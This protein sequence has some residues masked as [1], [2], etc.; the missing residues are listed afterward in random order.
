MHQ[1]SALYS[2]HYLLIKLLSIFLFAH[3]HPT[4]WTAQGLM[5]C[6]GDKISQRYRRGMYTGNDK[7]SNMSNISHQISTYL[8]SYLAKLDKIQY[9][10]ICSCPGYDH[11]RLAIF[12][13]LQDFIIIQYLSIFSHPVKI[14]LKE[15]T[16]E[17]DW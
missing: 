2:R 3:Y 1:W 7:S 9:A 14:D 17:I 11:F 4:P 16:R 8:I 6:G 10:R 12:S 15:F 5:S 13:N